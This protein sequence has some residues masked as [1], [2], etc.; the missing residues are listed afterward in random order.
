MKKT[1]LG[2]LAA[3]AVV[4]ATLAAGGASAHVKSFDSTVTL[5]VTDSYVYK[6]RVKSEEKDCYQHRGVTIY[7]EAGDEVLSGETNNRGRYRLTF[8]GEQYYAKVDK[9]TV[10]MGVHQ[11]TC[12][13]DK[14]ETTIRLAAGSEAL[15]FPRRDDRPRRA[16]ERVATE[17]T[18]NDRCSFDCRAALPR[19]NYTVDF[20][21]KVRSEAPQCERRRQVRLYRRAS[22]GPGYELIGKTESNGD[23]D[24]KITRTDK[25]GFTNY[26]VK[27]KAVR[28]GNTHCLRA[29][30]D[31]ESHE[32]V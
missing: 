10:G 13:A 32:F 7:N 2:S 15:N 26:L 30:S 21:G 4:A 5:R 8:V 16:D 24:W 11:H 6:G 19:R 3:C 27:T 29:T 22:S 1:G 17:V 28:K 14:S 9:V 31:K 18:I 20:F 12:R 23:G 25:P